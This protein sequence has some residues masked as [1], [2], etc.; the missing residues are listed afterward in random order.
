[1]HMHSCTHTYTHTHTHIHPPTHTTHT[2]AI[3]LQS[4]KVDG[5]D[6]GQPKPKRND[7]QQR[8]P[9]TS[10]FCLA[11]WWVFLPCLIRQRI[12]DKAWKRLFAN[13]PTI[14]IHCSSRGRFFGLALAAQFTWEKK[15]QNFPIPYTKSVG[16]RSTYRILHKSSKFCEL[17]WFV[18]CVCFVTSHFMR[19]YVFFSSLHFLHNRNIC[20]SRIITNDEAVTGTYI[21]P[22]QWQRCQGQHG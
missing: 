18:F 16:K 7:Q 17:F 11:R 12:I 1:M 15:Y 13:H 3:Y 22:P 9:V 10:P 21:F 20:C 19:F 14:P 8:L 2:L 6:V 5:V 4:L